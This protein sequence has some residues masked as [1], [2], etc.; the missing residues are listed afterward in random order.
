MLGATSGVSVLLSG[1]VITLFKDLLSERMKAAIKA[2][3]DE[4]LESYKAQLRAANDRELETLK[5]KLKAEADLEQE[6]LKSRLQI[7][8]AQENT[9]FIKLHERRVE[10]I[11][12][13]F[14]HLLP[15]RNAVGQYIRPFQSVGGPTDE[16]MLEAASRKYNAF[17]AFFVEKQLFLPR[18]VAAAVEKLDETFRS[19]TN[20]FTMVV[21]ADPK[22]PNA[23]LW[24][25]LVEQFGTEIDLAIEELLEDMR[26]ALGDKKPE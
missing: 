17:K 22:N 13:T 25:K 19:V 14:N 11:E 8:A 3:Y 6:R 10:A 16:Q 20:Q 5:V 2:E 23:Q 21:L 24:I 1:L 12:A 26:V 4:K 7:I 18:H 15:V 9:T